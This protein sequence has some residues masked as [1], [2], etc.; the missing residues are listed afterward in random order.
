LLS[1]PTNSVKLAGRSGSSHKSYGMSMSMG[2]RGESYNDRAYGTSAYSTNPYGGNHSEEPYQMTPYKQSKSKSW[3]MKMQDPEMKRK[4]RVAS[5][6]VFTVEGQ[7]KSSVRNSWRWIKNKY[8]DLR[9]GW[10]WFCLLLCLEPGRG[11]I[12]GQHV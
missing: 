12:A 10:W 1:G 3:D 4:K 11:D 5:Y 7:M 6:K 2:G 8:L 9:Y